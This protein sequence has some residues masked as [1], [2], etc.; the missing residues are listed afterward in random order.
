MHSQA[1]LSALPL[2]HLAELVSVSPGAE[3][4][5]DAPGVSDPFTYQMV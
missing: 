2:L 4:Q 1:E 5:G 3:G